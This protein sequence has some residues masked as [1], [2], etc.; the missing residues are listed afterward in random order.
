MTTVPSASALIARSAQSTVAGLFLQQ[1]RR[2]PSRPAVQTRD[3]TLTYAELADRAL[4]L[5]AVL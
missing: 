4:S 1:V 2:A 5:S 3:G